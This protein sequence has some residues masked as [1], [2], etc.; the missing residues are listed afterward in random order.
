MEHAKKL[1]KKYFGYDRFRLHQEAVI[2]RTLQM[3]SSLVIMP[4]GGG[5]SMCYQLPALILEGTTI[6]VSPLIALMQDQVSALSIAGISAAALN[7]AC[8]PESEQAI[9]KGIEQGQ[10]D[11][12]YVSPERA[13]SPGFL[14]WISAQK[15]AQI[16]IDE[17]H[18][19]SI[20]GNDF[21]PEYTRLTQ[22]TSLFPNNP[23]VAL[24][25]TADTATQQDICQQLNLLQAK[26]F[27]SSFERSNIHIDVL[28]S[29]D[30]VKLILKYIRSRPGQAGIIYCLSR[31]STEEMAMKLR[32]AN[33]KAAYYHANLKPEDKSALQDAFQRDE[34]QVICATIAFGMGIDK[35]NIRWVIHYNL[36]KNI[37]SYYQEIGRGGRD[38]EPASALLF[39]GYQDMKTLNEFID[40][41][42]GNE[43][44]QDVQ[45]A[46]LER[47]WSFTQSLSCRTNFILNYF[48]EYKKQGCG[49]CDHCLNPPLTIDGTVI[50]QMALS[51]CYRTAQSANSRQLIDVLRGA[52]NRET[53]ERNYHQLKTYGVGKEHSWKA[54]NYYLTQLVDRGYLSI[55]FTAS[56]NLKLTTLSEPVLKQKEAVLLCQYQEHEKSILEAKSSA[57][58]NSDLSADQQ[59]LFEKLKNLRKEIADEQKVPAFVV[60]NDASLKDML[61]LMPKNLGEFL[62]V[63]GVG[64]K[65]CDKYGEEFLALL[66]G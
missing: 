61:Q 23:V 58:S 42:K 5:K 66:N 20:W 38:G 63:S 53:I 26:T 31:R 62:D 48:G 17:A 45:R 18:C 2:E 60:F 30:R 37:E 4:T 47:M 7:S 56:N 39:A 15:I 44:F 21:R 49:H 8:T 10:I 29:K 46:K 55:D 43:V 65:K 35:P 13:V 36:P 25:A 1:L 3:Q 27:I 54:W 22:L 33:I 64:D 34:V 40:R 24:T 50:A 11:L 12:L 51:A 41:A 28:P 9:I 32:A 6:V 57:D 19:V 16:A 14:S 52:Q 59:V